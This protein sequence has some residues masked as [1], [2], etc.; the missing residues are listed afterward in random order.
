MMGAYSRA[1][2]T[3][4]LKYALIIIIRDALAAHPSQNW[5]THK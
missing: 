1:S 2:I 5:S 3:R 4:S